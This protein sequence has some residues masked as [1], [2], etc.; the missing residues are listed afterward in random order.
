MT[1]DIPS[2]SSPA[3]TD[4]FHSKPF[5]SGKNRLSPFQDISVW[6]KIIS[7]IPGYSV[8]PRLTSSIPSHSSQAKT[9]FLNSKPFRST[10]YCQYTLSS[11]LALSQLVTELFS[12][13]LNLK[14]CLS[15]SYFDFS[16]PFSPLR[17][18]P[19]D[20]LCRLYCLE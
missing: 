8:R 17:T 1:F 9:D 19:T 5:Q 13:C 7:F 4:F 6:Q 15:E 18:G 16:P 3:K 11:L 14:C 12:S 10:Q 20:C 2:Y